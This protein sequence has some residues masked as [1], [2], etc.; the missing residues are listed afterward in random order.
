ME[1]DIFGLAVYVSEGLF[2]TKISAAHHR[3][4]LW[5]GI[6]FGKGDVGTEV[7]AVPIS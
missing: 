5:R 2:R 1:S 3:R 4:H 7:S 6:Q